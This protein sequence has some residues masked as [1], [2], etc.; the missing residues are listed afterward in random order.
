M[1]PDSIIAVIGGKIRVGLAQ[2]EM[3]GLARQ[4]GVLKLSRADI[5]HALVAGASGSTTVAATMM[6]AALAGIEVFATGGIGGVHRGAEVSLD[7][8]ADLYEFSRSD[9]ITVA[10]GAK[11]ILDLDK[12]LEVLETQGVAVIGYGTDVFP[13]FWSRSSGLR[14]PMR[15]DSH[16]EIADYWRTRKAIG[17]SGG[18]LIANPVPEAAEIPAEKIAGFIEQ[19][20]RDLTANGVAG[21]QV[22]PWLLSRI[23]ELSDG[24]SLDTNVALIRNNAQLAAGIAVALAQ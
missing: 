4:E 16:Q 8:S 23:M 18:V 15:F 2:A 5:A 7:V 24:Q 22:T 11:A 9:V 6:A 1:Q 21:K 14:C 20:L 13:A 10:A 19:A 3:E 17:Q 12:T